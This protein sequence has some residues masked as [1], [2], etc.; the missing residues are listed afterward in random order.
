MFKLYDHVRQ[1]IILGHWRNLPLTFLQLGCCDNHPRSSSRYAPPR[2]VSA[3]HYRGASVVTW[4]RRAQCRRFPGNQFEPPLSQ[5]CSNFC[6][7]SAQFGVNL[8]INGDVF[9][10]KLLWICQIWGRKNGQIIILIARILP[11]QFVYQCSKP[12]YGFLDSLVYK[13]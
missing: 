5:V 10:H 6:R 4:W 7:L 8:K 13:I 11:S 2:I 3:S 12:L 9:R 1:L